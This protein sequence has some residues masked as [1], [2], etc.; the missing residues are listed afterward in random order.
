L[1]EKKAKKEKKEVYVAKDTLL[2]KMIVQAKPAGVVPEI[3]QPK[4]KK[5]SEEGG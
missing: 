3:P 4:R 5:G 1:S 2:E